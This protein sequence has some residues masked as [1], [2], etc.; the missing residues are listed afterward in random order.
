MKNINFIYIFLAIFF[1]YSISLADIIDDDNFRPAQSDA[2]K[3]LEVLFNAYYTRADLNI[4]N[5]RQGY[6]THKFYNTTKFVEAKNQLERNC[7]PTIPD[8]GYETCNSLGYSVVICGK[9]M[10]DSRIYFTHKSDDENYV[11]ISVK[12]SD[13][14]DRPM[15]TYSLQKQGDQWALDESECLNRLLSE[16]LNSDIFKKKD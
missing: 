7:D 9:D 3:A 5:L 11:K 10:P 14:P 6:F 15:I 2:E 8:Y 4:E 12:F 1:T 13:Y 16:V